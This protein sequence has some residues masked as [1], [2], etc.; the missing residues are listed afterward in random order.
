[1][2]DVTLPDGKVIHRAK[3]S[4]DLTTDEFNEFMGK[5]EEFAMER[6][7]YLDQLEPT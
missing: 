3:S 7:I 2:D 4:S 1:M 5:V 6:D